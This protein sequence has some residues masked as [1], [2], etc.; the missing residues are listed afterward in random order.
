MEAFFTASID[1]KGQSIGRNSL[2]NLPGYLEHELGVNDP[3]FDERGN[4]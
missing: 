4:S 3:N 1:K 2:E